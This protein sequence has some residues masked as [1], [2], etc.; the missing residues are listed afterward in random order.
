MP[1]CDSVWR[2]AT[3]RPTLASAS[4]AACGAPPGTR[5]RSHPP[6]ARSEAGRQA[7]ALCK[8]DARAGALSRTDAL[9]FLRA[10][11]LVGRGV[12]HSRP[13]SVQDGARARGMRNP[14]ACAWDAQRPCGDWRQGPCVQV[15]TRV[16]AGHLLPVVA[17]RTQRQTA[18][19]L[20]CASSSCTRPAPSHGASLRMCGAP[21][22]PSSDWSGE[23]SRRTVQRV[24]RRAALG[25][26]ALGGGGRADQAPVLRRMQ[27]PIWNLP[28][29]P[30]P[31][32]RLWGAWQACAAAG[33]GRRGAH[34]AARL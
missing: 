24:T 33:R 31:P 18:S 11:G 32:L 22:V 6:P 17:R 14:D 7:L 2:P 1:R 5:A 27:P 3:R 21:D 26:V 28:G 20:R 9:S 25:R 16:T 15:R 8:L 10:V 13:C 30:C 29:L 12:A 34:P 23:R 19:T 4:C